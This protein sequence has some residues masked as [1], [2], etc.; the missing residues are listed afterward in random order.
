[1]SKKFQ[2]CQNE[3]FHAWKYSRSFVNV[4]QRPDMFKIFRSPSCSYIRFVLSIRF[5][6]FRLYNK[7]NIT[8][9]L[10]LEIWILCSG[11]KKQT[12]KQ[13]IVRQYLPSAREILVFFYWN[14]KI[15][16]S[17]HLVISS[18]YSARPRT[19]N[20]C[21]HLR[22]VPWRLWKL[23]FYYLRCKMYV[24][25]F[26]SQAGAFKVFSIIS[27][28]LGAATAF[29]YMV[30]IILEETNETRKGE[31]PW[32]SNYDETTAILGMIWFSGLLNLSWVFGLQWAFLGR[33][34]LALAVHHLRWAVF[35]ISPV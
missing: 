18:I 27:A 33:G 2:K 9:W 4:N 12:N 14:I 22:K 24:I 17:R 5:C 7:K 11:G 16:S 1:M 21:H 29:L 34:Y 15:I 6:C 20:I 3:E 8:H 26:N 19:N 35:K 23:L 13:T 10:S 28:L 32:C 31:N 25:L 30:A